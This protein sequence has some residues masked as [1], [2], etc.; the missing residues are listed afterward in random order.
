MIFVDSCILIDYSKGKIVIEDKSNLCISS[1][2]EMEF[3]VGALN[4]RE[5]IKIDKIVS[6]FLLIETNQDILDL[7]TKL[8]DKYSLSH[9]MAIYDSIIA[10][11]CLIYD[12]ILWTYNKKDFK[13][14]NGL[15]LKE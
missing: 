10:S 13:F 9:N 6:E 11:T 5:K 15:K 8:I 12:L 2:V 14:I 4:K 7:S 1:I 3:K